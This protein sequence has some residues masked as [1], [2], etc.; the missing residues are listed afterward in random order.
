MRLIFANEFGQEAF[1][2]FAQ[3]FGGDA[4]GFSDLKHIILRC[5]DIGQDNAKFFCFGK[6]SGGVF[7][8]GGDDVASLVFA[9][10]VGDMG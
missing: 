7:G 2:G 3:C 10:K 1:I 9:K 4:K 6:K 8:V 5:A